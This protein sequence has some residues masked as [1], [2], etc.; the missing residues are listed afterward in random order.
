MKKSFWTGMVL[1]SVGTGL[2]MQKISG[3]KLLKKLLKK[4]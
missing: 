4:A 1:G 3:N 2:L